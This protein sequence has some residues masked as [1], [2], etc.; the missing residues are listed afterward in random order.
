MSDSP[1]APRRAGIQLHDQFKGTTLAVT[2]L[3]WI[4]M[5]ASLYLLQTHLSAFRFFAFNN[6]S[7]NE[8][9]DR[10]SQISW[11][12]LLWRLLFLLTFG[13][14][15]RWKFLASEN[16]HRLT[17]QTMEFSSGWA[18]G[19][20]LIPVA[21]LVRPYEVMSELWRVSADPEGWPHAPGNA[22]VRIWWALWLLAGV[23]W[24]TGRF[25]L[26]RPTTLSGVRLGMAI[27][28][29]GDV[30]WIAMFGFLVSIVNT[31]ANNQRRQTQA[32]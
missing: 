23:A 8:V 17:A 31:I 32:V 10:Y 25:A 29:A 6:L 12:T 28:A 1:S 18:A 19:W 30:L 16:C 27:L 2:V 5:A 20:D 3:F 4:T 14:F 21:M 7:L 9:I 24:F 26:N 11:V 13:M 15:L 22:Q